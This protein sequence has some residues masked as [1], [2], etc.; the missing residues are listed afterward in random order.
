MGEAQEPSQGTQPL[1]VEGRT[2]AVL[3]G[4]ETGNA[5]DIAVELGK[6]AQRLHFQTAVDDM[7]SFKLVRCGWTQNDAGNC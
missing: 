2:M 3:Y 7:D 4:S 1:V 5:E 6:M